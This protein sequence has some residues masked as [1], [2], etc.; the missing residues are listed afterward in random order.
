MRPSALRT[1]WLPMTVVHED[2]DVFGYD[3]AL[4]KRVW[5]QI[6]SEGLVNEYTLEWVSTEGKSLEFIGTKIENLP[7][8]FRARKVHGIHCAE[9][10]IETYLLAPLAMVSK[11]TRWRVCCG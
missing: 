11:C 7:S 2:F 9:E 6:H 3:T 10:I 4:K 5:I 8:G 1:L